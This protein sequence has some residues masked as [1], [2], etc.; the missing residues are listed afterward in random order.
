[1]NWIAI[2]SSAIMYAIS[3]LLLGLGWN[4]NKWEKDKM[5]KSNGTKKQLNWYFIIPGLL[6]GSS[7]V[8]LS[9]IGVNWDKYFNKHDNPSM[10]A[11][12]TGNNSPATVVGQQTNNYYGKPH[13]EIICGTHSNTLCPLKLISF[14][15][16]EPHDTNTEYDGIKWNFKDTDVR[17]FIKNIDSNT[18]KDISLE[19]TC[20]IQIR[21]IRQVTQIP[22]VTI[23]TNTNM[24]PMEVY[25]LKVGLADQ[26]G[27]KITI[28]IDVTNM[29]SQIK[30]LTCPQLLPQAEIELV[31]ACIATNPMKADGSFPDTY[32]AP[33]RNPKW[34]QFNGFYRISQDNSENKFNVKLELLFNKKIN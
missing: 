14:M 24:G 23:A 12:T 32:Y 30:R 3:T 19:I 17:I 2:I 4:W 26:K 13:K 29:S 21:T 5:K 20:D 33:R 28:P 11:I 1:M 15:Y 8:F 31:L 10:Q 6:I 16:S 9:V 7:A 34:I 27:N 25:A 18:I 22:D